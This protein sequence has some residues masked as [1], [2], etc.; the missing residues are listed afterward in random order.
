[1]SEI[2]IIEGEVFQDA[3]GI[4]NSLNEFHFDGVRRCYFISHPDPSVVRG[5]HGHQHERKWFYCVKGDFTLACVKIDDWEHPS[6]SLQAEIFQL[7]DMQS[8]LVCVPAGYANCLKTATAG[9]VMAVFSDKIVS[10]AL[11]DSW[12]YDKNRWVDWSNY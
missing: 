9:S 3:R 10:D 5:W 8:R 2:K 12:R 4:I 7:S 1:M 11:Q 6:P